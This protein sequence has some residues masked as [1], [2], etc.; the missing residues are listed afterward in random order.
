MST[1]SG[2]T[3]TASGAFGDMGAGVLGAFMVCSRAVREA[4][5][6]GARS[7]GEGGQATLAEQV[8]QAQQGAADLRF[9]GAQR[10][11]GLGGDLLV[12]EPAEEGER[13]Q[14]T[15]LRAEQHQRPVQVGMVAGDVEQFVARG[16]RLGAAVRRGGLVVGEALVPE[17]R[18]APQRI[19]R[20]RLRAIASSQV[21][22]LPRARSNRAAWRQTWK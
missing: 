2:A 4:A 13:D 15:R 17:A 5:G 20:A 9:H 21:I 16:H 14:L 10:Q 7:R 3:P 1:G 19:D 12:A 8:A 11:A 6:A 22:A 18:L